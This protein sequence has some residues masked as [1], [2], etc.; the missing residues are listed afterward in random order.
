MYCKKLLGC[1]QVSHKRE[2]ER[3]GWTFSIQRTEAKRELAH[4]TGSRIQ[5]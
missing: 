1:L 4:M 3:E 5:A 2:E